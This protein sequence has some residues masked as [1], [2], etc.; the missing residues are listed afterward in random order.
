MLNSAAVFARRKGLMKLR[1]VA[2]VGLGLLSFGCSSSRIKPFEVYSPDGKTTYDSDSLRGRVVM[3][4]YWATWCQPCHVLQPSIRSISDK[5]GPRGLVVLGVSNEAPKT[6]AEYVR[7]SPLGYT[8]AMDRG[9]QVGNQ[10]NVRGL[11]TIIIIDKDGS[12]V[13]NSTVPELKDITS[14]LD[15]LLPEKS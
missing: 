8:A 3:I 13:Y 5:Y 7:K 9:D 14:T 1:Y 4:D 6:V 12:L 10:F 15:R 11:P 2:L